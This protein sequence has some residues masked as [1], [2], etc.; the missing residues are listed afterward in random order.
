[1]LVITCRAYGSSGSPAS[2]GGEDRGL[3][4]TNS[5]EDHRAVGPVYV[6][7][8]NTVEWMLDSP[9]SRVAKAHLISSVFD[10]S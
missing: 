4:R 10:M 9:R 6:L 2:E 5:I 8:T 7:W 1:M 3:G